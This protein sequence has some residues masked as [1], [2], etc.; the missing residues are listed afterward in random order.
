M[1]TSSLKIPTLLW[2]RVLKQ[3]R[4]RG[5][6]T[7]ES[8]AF[9]LG[10]PGTRR[11]SHFVCYDELDE[12]AL[13]TGIVMF[14]AAGFVRLWELCETRQL[15]VLA[16]VHTHPSGWTG[17]SESDRT[18]PMIA[19]PGHLALILPHFALR[20]RGGLNGAG[21]YE[22]LGNHHWKTWPAKS[23]PVKITLL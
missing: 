3:L 23:G 22:Y 19:Q 2:R 18:H 12:T 17:Q 4:K 1:K 8:G 15:K 20:M 21:V 13:E 9:L 14:H 10:K 16:D 7:H 6:G 5:H 11:I